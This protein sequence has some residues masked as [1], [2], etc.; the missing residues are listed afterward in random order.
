MISESKWA[1]QTLSKWVFI[2]EKEFLFVA[3]VANHPLGRFS[4]IWL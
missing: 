1:D 2:F 4:H 3:K